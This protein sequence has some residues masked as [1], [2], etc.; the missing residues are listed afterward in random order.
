[1]QHPLCMAERENTTPKPS[2][3]CRYEG[4]H[5]DPPPEGLKLQYFRPSGG[6]RGVALLPIAFMPDKSETLRHVAMVC[7]ACQRGIYSEQR[8]CFNRVRSI[9][10][11]LWLSGITRAEQM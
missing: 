1:M 7:S 9:D 10:I 5:L 11:R 4:R 8:Y 3:P 2:Y 6:V